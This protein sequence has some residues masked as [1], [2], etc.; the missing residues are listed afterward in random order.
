MSNANA[1]DW[2][3]ADGVDG[4]ALEITGDALETDFSEGM[5]RI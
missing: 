3:I 2:A 5:H 4:M 1:N